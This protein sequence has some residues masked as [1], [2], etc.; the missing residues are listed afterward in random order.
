V[1]IIFIH[2]ESLF[3]L[4]GSNLRGHA[5]LEALVAAGHE[6]DLVAPA[7][8]EHLGPG[9]SLFPT[10]LIDRFSKRKMLQ[11]LRFAYRA[12]AL[13]S[14]L[15][16]AYDAIYA[17]RLGSAP[18]ARRLARR[19]ALEGGVGARSPG[20][21]MIADLWE[22]D[23]LEIY[24]FENPLLRAAAAVT[25]AWYQKHFLRE[26][27]RV[28]VLTEAMRKY[29]QSRYGVE[30]AVSYD[31]ADATR[32][33]I[34]EVG[35]PPTDAA[36]P[37]RI[38]FHGGIDR[39]DGVLEFLEA[40]G[41]IASRIPA[42]FHLMGTGRALPE[43]E[44]LVAKEW[45]GK[46]VRIRGWVPYG[47]IASAIQNADLAVIPSLDTPMNRMV[48]PRKTF[49]YMSLGVPIVATALPAM[50]ELLTEDMAT[51]VPAG[52][53]VRLA[54]EVVRLAGDPGLRSRQRAALLRRA[55]SLTLQNEVAKIVRIVERVA[56]S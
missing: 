29:L 11:H 44:R 14:S 54:D 24:P 35:F 20:T 25:G 50:R 21:P 23:L 45:W 49:E 12:M 9:I 5:I 22:V 41:H 53:T 2:A 31:A 6:V 48:I 37:F 40:F 16:P 27:S 36:T 46:Q 17:H 34:G 43:I 52:S 32:F 30:S 1:R 33:R 56:I 47:E 18:L 38:V 10:P 19:P 7:T 42:E 4:S 55:E 13:E 8:D 39:R 51:L 15:R 26:A 28:I 3:P